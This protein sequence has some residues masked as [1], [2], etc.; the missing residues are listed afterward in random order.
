MTDRLISL[1]VFRGITIASMILVNNPGSWEYVLPPLQHAAWH[2]WTPT[3]LVFPFFL[4]IVGVSISYAISKRITLAE[5]LKPVYFKVFKRTFILFGLGLFLNVFPFF[6]LSD[7]RIPGVL[8]RIAICYLFGSL[9]YVKTNPKIRIIL[10]AV[11]LFGYWV[12]LKYVP[13]P[14]YGAGDWSLEGNLAAFVDVKLLGG[15]L[16]KPLFDPEG[17]L[18][19]IPA[20][21]TTLIGTFI[22]DGLRSGLRQM[23]K[24][25]GLIGV[26]ILG[27]G[28]GIWLHGFFPINKQLWTSSYVLFTAGV[29]TLVLAV[30]YFVLDCY[31]WDKWAKPFLVFG[32]N[33]I[34]VFV[35]SSLLARLLSVFKVKSF[36]FRSLLEPWAGPWLASLIFPIGLLLIWW[37]ILYPLY[38]RHI[39]IKI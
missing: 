8:Q 20:I 5:T 35:G 1:D 33:A 26:G 14:G 3:D 32:T 22:G 25:A 2:G 34:A 27:V 15:H 11:L 6:Q 13:V 31:G 37:A 12:V 29:A 24:L 36:I 28:A 21:A 17:I 10:C 30:C 4:F 16:H 38:K 9:L 19:T 39:Y 7:M 18:S 23:T